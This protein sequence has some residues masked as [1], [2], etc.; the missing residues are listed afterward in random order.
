M[1]TAD[2][3]FLKFDSPGLDLS[4]RSSDSMRN[5]NAAAA[6]AKRVLIVSPRFPPT[7]AADHH[8]VR[9]MLPT[10]AHFGWRAVV[11]A[12]DSRFVEAPLEEDLLL[13]I[14]DDV[15]V[16]RC[17]A[18]PQRLTRRFRFGS[19]SLR[20][21]SFLRK[22]GDELLESRKFDLVFFSTTEFGIL[23]LGRRWKDRYGVP[24]VVDLQDPWVNTHYANTGRR[25]PGGVLKHTA[26]Q[27][28]ARFSEG[29]TLQEAAHI[30]SVSP[31]YKLDLCQKYPALSPSV[32]SVIPFGGSGTDF[33]VMR[34]S[35]R[36]QRV[37]D[38]ADGRTHW[39]Y[40]GTAPPGIRSALLGFFL[41][42]RRAFRERIID[43]HSIRIHFVGTDYAP[44]AT[45][46]PRILPI[47]LEVG[48]SQVVGEH[49][50]RIPYLETLRCLSDADALLVLGW[51]DPGYTASKLYP[52]ILADKP[53]L[54][55]LH[56]ESSANEVM[57]ETKAGTAVCFTGRS[58]AEE[59]AEKIFDAWFTSRSFQ[60]APETIWDAFQQYTAEAMTRRVATVFDQA[61]R[62]TGAGVSPRPPEH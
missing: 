17:R 32:F 19:L 7:S 57:R 28:V 48:V 38:P 21:T 41:A 33:E 15:E 13:T 20:A 53:L 45:A 26:T 55:V 43:E 14:P 24:F 4:G 50:A 46:M 40:A 9:M 10:L 52:Y 62:Q 51:D 42:L 34:R 11:L 36:R 3:N 47:A 61:A 30:I 54:T 1:A 5:R 8:R 23:S 56:E 44:P 37:F 2:G 16:V 22:A 39:I 6:S 27:A 31:K 49:P 12:V 58:S 29:R 25:P 59:V 35:S 18:I 60:T